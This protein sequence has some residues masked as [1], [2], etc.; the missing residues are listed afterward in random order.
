MP[1][2]L[3]S[4]I[5]ITFKK[6]RRLNPKKKMNKGEQVMA[7]KQEDLK[8]LFEKEDHDGSENTLWY[9]TVL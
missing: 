9:L 6:N 7:G 8:M 4:I 3:C 5:F 1:E 2:L